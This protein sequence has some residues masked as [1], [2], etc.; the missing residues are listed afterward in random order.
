MSEITAPYPASDIRQEK[1]WTAAKILYTGL[2][3]FCLLSY[4]WTLAIGAGINN[5]P[6]VIWIARLVSVPLAVYLGRLWKNKGFW[7]VFFIFLDQADSIFG[8]ALVVWLFYDIGIL[9]YLGFVA[10]GAVTHLILN[11]LLYFAHLRKNM[12]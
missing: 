4:L 10:V 12:F 2:T 6:T 7:K 9:L 1:S 5:L 11:M 3:G 8:V